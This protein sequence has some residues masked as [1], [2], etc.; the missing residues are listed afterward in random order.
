MFVL[1]MSALARSSGDAVFKF[2]PF[3][4]HVQC[5]QLD[6]AQLMVRTVLKLVRVFRLMSVLPVS[7]CFALT[8]F[9]T[10]I[11]MLEQRSSTVFST[12]LNKNILWIVLSMSY[13]RF[14]AVPV[15]RSATDMKKKKSNQ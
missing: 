8:S 15:S 9:H 14:T 2:E 1:Q 6:D 13:Q 12:V 3:V 4:L 11:S 7:I 5:R 10:H